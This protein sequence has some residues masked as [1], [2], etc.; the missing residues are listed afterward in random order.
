MTACYHDLWSCLHRPDLGDTAA[1]ELDGSSSGS[2]GEAT[3]SAALCKKERHSDRCRR[4]SLLPGARGIREVSRGCLR[5]EI[6]CGKHAA[7]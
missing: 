1:V 5:V 6:E 4:M 3:P 2:S 7:N